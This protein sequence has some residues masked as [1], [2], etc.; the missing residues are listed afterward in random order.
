MSPLLT[1]RHSASPLGCYPLPSGK[2]E[3]G[4]E[5]HTNR[6]FRFVQPPGGQNMPLAERIRVKRLI[7]LRSSEMRA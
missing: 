7:R 3:V 5:G 4:I 6:H 1:S 2:G